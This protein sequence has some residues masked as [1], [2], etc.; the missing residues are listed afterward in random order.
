MEIEC[1]I[2][3]TD[4]ELKVDER[5]TLRDFLIEEMGKNSVHYG[6]DST[7]CGACAVFVDGTAVKSCSMFAPKINGKEVRTLEGVTEQWVEEN[8]DDEMH[9]LQEIWVEENAY[10]CGYCT[11]GFL[12]STLDLLENN[13]KDVGEDEI[14][15]AL[16]GNICRC[17]G[18]V[19]I[20]DA[21][22][23]AIDEL[24][25]ETL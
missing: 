2:D 5:D 24:G 19:N 22:D 20:V 7:R 8:P 12:V 23:R 11:P 10:Q 9:P 14:R 4:Y 21:V 17:T 16:E 13:G 18:Y 25:G 6:C 3:D 15:K 1:T